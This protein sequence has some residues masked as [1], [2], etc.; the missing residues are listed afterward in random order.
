[1]TLGTS[2]AHKKYIQ[3]LPYTTILLRNS[4]REQ[5]MQLV[6]KVNNSHMHFT[7]GVEES[8]GI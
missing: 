6:L 5:A 4:L 8:I 1:M 3:H 7:K 2:T